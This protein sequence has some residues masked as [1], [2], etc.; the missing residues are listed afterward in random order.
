MSKSENELKPQT[1]LW[2]YMDVARFLSLIDRK[3]LYFPRL[4]ELRNIRPTEQFIFR[5]NKGYT[6]EQEVRALIYET[7]D[8]AHA[9]FSQEVF[10]NMR[11]QRDPEKA[12]R[13][14]CAGGHS[15]SYPQNRGFPS[16][17]EL[18]Y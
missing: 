1:V 2:R 11:L 17:P 12:E 14:E 10:D 18:G 6:H 16:V 13:H 4:H 9:I 3:E 8:G 7:Y 15:G 5:K